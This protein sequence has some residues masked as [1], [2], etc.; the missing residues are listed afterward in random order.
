MDNKRQGRNVFVS[1]FRV[2]DEYER[3]RMEAERRAALA[4]MLEAQAYQPLNVNQPAPIAPSQGLAKVLK[5]YM[6][7]YEKRK[8]REAEEKAKGEELE[9]ASEIQG[10]LMGLDEIFSRD[11]EGKL[12]SVYATPEEQQAQIEADIARQRA[13][14]QLE[15][16]VPTAQYQRDPMDALRLASTPAGVAATRGNP[17]LAAML[18]KSMETGKA[19]KSPYGSVDPAKFT[20]ASIEK[21]DASVRA[22]NPDYTLLQPREYSELTRQQMIDTAFRTGE[23]GIKGGQYEFETGRTAPKL[24]M[25]SFMVGAQ[26]FGQTA[27]Q[28]PSAMPMTAAPAMPSAAPPVTP[29]AA[30]QPAPSAAMAAPL[31]GTQAAADRGPPA[32]EVATP[33]Q[34]LK[35]Q[36]EIPVARR[37]AITGLS[38]LDSLDNI[39]ADLEQHP[40][41][42]NIS[43]LIG[44]IPLDI[45]PEA[46]SARGKLTEFKEATSLQAVQDARESSATGG[47][48]G[49]MTVQEWPRLESLF[50]AILASKDPEELRKSIRNARARI[51][52]SKNLYTTK[53]RDTY[54]NLDIGYSPTP[55][56]PESA[57][58]LE[59]DQD[60]VFKQAD[61]ILRGGF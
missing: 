43:G 23:F 38:K 5:Q 57:R 61:A 10:R 36:Q 9:T 31:G 13:S 56:E 25:P 42:D 34:S 54:G 20:T 21:F 19:S 29:T 58:F 32:I 3:A 47:A 14:G 6:G 37:A 17:M 44:Q 28:A 46:R 60:D 4:E 1:T 55:Y 8:A 50:G 22:G 39:L 45:A 7:A 24:Q 33:Q 11:K 41:L 18:Q 52:A 59:S 35:L 15:E 49:S 2:P 53:W 12:Q 16:M 27:P 48:Y 40:G 51:A 30:A 26:T